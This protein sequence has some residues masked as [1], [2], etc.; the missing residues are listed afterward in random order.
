MARIFEPNEDLE[1]AGILCVF[2]GFQIAQL[3]QKDRHAPQAIYAEFPKTKVG[4]GFCPIFNC[5]RRL[6]GCDASSRPKSGI[7]RKI[8]LKTR[9]HRAEITEELSLR[10]SPKKK[11]TQGHKWPENGPRF[12]GMQSHCFALQIA[13]YTHIFACKRDASRLS[14]QI[15][16]SLIYC[17]SRFELIHHYH[18]TVLSIQA[19][20]LCVLPVVGFNEALFCQRLQ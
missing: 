19:H 15:F 3:G 10:Y 11:G 16:T 13:G 1:T 2:Q 14:R 17:N 5:V 18:P 8:S 7:S 6:A 9:P 4:L 12:T 20:G